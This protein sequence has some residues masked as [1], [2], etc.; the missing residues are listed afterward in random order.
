MKVF[1]GGTMQS[2]WREQLKL[3][4]RC[5]TVDPE[6]F[7]REHDL[8]NALARAECDLLIYVITP[9][10]ICAT[11]IAEAVDCSNK[12]PSK[13]IFAYLSSDDSGQFDLQQ[14]AKLNNIG[15][16]VA[17]NG[18]AFFLTLTAVANYLNKLNEFHNLHAVST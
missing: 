6:S 16:I 3:M 13:T 18:G 8:K 15:Q 10:E 11:A 14:K 12:L 17:R 9:R 4:V 5:K 1:L 7:V 2:G